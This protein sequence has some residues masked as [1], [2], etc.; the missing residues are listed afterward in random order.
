MIDYLEWYKDL[1]VSV[2][3]REDTYLLLSS[4]MCE[5]TEMLMR[6]LGEFM[7]RSAGEALSK[8]NARGHPDFLESVSLRYGCAPSQVVATNGASNAI[9]LLCSTLLD[10]GDKIVVESPCYEPLLSTARDI[11]CEVVPLNRRPPAFDI[12]LDELRNLLDERTRLVMLTN[13][14]NPSGSFLSDDK[15]REIGKVVVANSDAYV[16][17]DEIYRDFVTEPSTNAF[18]LGDRFMSLGS[19]TKVHGL[20]SIHVGWIVAPEKV[21]RRIL[22]TQTLVEG[23]GSRLL[24]GFGAYLIRRLD[25]YI[26][27]SLATVARNRGIVEDLLFRFLDTGLIEGAIPEYGCIWF[28]KLNCPGGTEEFVRRVAKESSLYLVPGRFFGYSEHVRIG[29]GS[30]TDHLRRAVDILADALSKIS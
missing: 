15:L 9:Y 7:S 30:R 24:E 1:E 2:F 6:H 8:T 17:V 26:E 13:L 11:G 21:T 27:S 25:D 18:K 23:A 16:A 28:P 5:P 4:S 12:N 19:L 20:G 22:T 14:H 29:Y 10:R 3:E